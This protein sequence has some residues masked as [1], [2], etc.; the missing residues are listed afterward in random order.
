MIELG[1]SYTAEE[2]LKQVKELAETY[3]EHLHYRRAGESHDG[4]EIPGI[5]LGDSEKCLLVSGG[6][7]GR[8]SVNPVLLLRMAE[9]YALLRENEYR[10]PELEE[11][12]Q[13]L[14]DYSV[15]FLPLVNPDGYETALRGFSEIRD[16]SLRTSIQKMKIPHEEW[17]ENG[18]GVDINRNFP[19]KSYLP[20]EGMAEAASELETQALIHAF[21]EF[22]LSVGY[23]DF[24]SR[25]KVIYYYR[26]AMSWR[27]NRKGKRMAKHLQKI[28]DYV[29]GKRREERHTPYDGGNSVNY[30]SETY[31]K[32]ALTV[33]TVED[34]AIFPM[35]VSYQKG[36][37]QEIRWMPIEFLKQYDGMARR[38]S[39][40]EII[41]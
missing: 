28:S 23:M 16:L 10:D 27:Y 17:K 21:D 15:Y 20:R 8:E 7:H 14:F 29:P 39:S 24:H 12:Q 31:G 18:R 41:T 13:L 3:P 36:T 38:K 9:D 35:D 34:E 40:L 32:L 30:Y 19:C 25:G 4:R 37:Y 11:E 22:P 26:S 33:E 1:K 5:L 2:I 6:I